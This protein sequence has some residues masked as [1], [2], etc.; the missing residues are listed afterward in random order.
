MCLVYLFIFYFLREGEKIVYS[1]V[2]LINYT[3]ITYN[4]D[5]FYNKYIKIINMV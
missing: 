2:K 1:Y 5:Q 3:F 4:T